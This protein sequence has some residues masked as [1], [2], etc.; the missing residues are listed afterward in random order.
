VPGAE[1][2]AAYENK[3]GTDCVASKIAGQ[4]EIDEYCSPE[5]TP[6]QKLL[7]DE[8]EAPTRSAGGEGRSSVGRNG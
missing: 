2:T 8:S 6:P 1:A 7:R 5:I 4:K 3:V